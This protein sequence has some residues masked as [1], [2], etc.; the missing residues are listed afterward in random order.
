MTSISFAKESIPAKHQELLQMLY[1]LYTPRYVHRKRL[2][3]S[4]VHQND[5]WVIR[6]TTRALIEAWQTDMV[7]IGDD[8]EQDYV[9]PLTFGW[10]AD[11][12]E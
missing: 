4:R 8:N 7:Y 6:Q 2:H 1:E 3:H 11:V 5:E 9:S 12:H 10:E